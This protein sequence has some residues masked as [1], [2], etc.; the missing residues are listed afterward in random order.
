MCKAGGGHL[1]HMGWLYIDR[2]HQREQVRRGEGIRGTGHR[3]T[4]YISCV[5]AGRCTTL[6]KLSDK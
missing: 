2:G 6:I 4:A 3:M 1:D 5:I